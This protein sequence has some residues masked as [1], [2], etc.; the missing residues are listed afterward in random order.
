MAAPLASEDTKKKDARKNRDTRNFRD[1]GRKILRNDVFPALEE[2]QKSDKK[3]NFMRL[4]INNS[5]LTIDRSSESP[6]ERERKSGKI[7][8]VENEGLSHFFAF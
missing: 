4:R 8:I 2:K 3:N 1:G 5:G 7:K 6:R